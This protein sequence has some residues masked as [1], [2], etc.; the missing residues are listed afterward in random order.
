[1][2]YREEFWHGT[3]FMFLFLFAD[4]IGGVKMFTYV[5][6]TVCAYVR[7]VDATSLQPV[8]YLPVS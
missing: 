8:Q 1:M 2:P 6:S 4:E 3:K 5:C 7:V